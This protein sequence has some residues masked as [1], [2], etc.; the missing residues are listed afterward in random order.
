MI[1]RILGEGQLDVPES[2]LGRLNELDAAV[3]QA[4]DA[5]DEAGFAGGLKA[6]LDAVRTAGTPLPDD[7]LVDSEFILPPADG[8]LEE[9]RALLSD[10][11][12]IPG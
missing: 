11:G 2:E 10:D 12:L 1:V 6:L 9:V 5:G 3:Q 8:T 7:A 4:V